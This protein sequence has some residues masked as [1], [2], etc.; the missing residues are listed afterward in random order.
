MKDLSWVLI[1]V[2][3]TSVWTSSTGDVEV[4]C[5]FHQSCILPCSFHG[6]SET[7]IH[8]THLAAGESAVHSYYDGEDQLGRQDQNFR[9]RTSLF[10]DQ[11]SRGNASL[12][13]RGVQVQDG[14]RY[15]CSF[16]IT[17]ADMSFVNVMVEA[18]VSKVN[19]T[20]VDDGLICSSEGI[21]P[22]PELTWST[23]PPSN[24]I[25]KSTTMVRLAE[26]QL[27]SI[28]SSLTVS[29]GSDQV[30]ICTVRTSRSSMEAVTREKTK[31]VWSIGLIV[32][33]VLLAALMGVLPCI[34]EKLKKRCKDAKSCLFLRQPQRAEEPPRLR[35]S[36]HTEQQDEG[37]R[38]HGGQ[39]EEDA[40]LGEDRITI[41]QETKSV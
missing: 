18:P 35:A 16:S 22:E 31:T 2:V 11:I 3:L 13:L 23:V 27:Y 8:W 24:I 7:V 15:R 37:I 40:C 10:Q 29:D 36:C 21:Y 1:W 6:A 17:D 19:I 5:V 28:S 26:Q 32:L 25:L 38:P 4:F 20:E 41:Q 34:C 39:G 9:G 14:G 12:L 30:Y 33:V